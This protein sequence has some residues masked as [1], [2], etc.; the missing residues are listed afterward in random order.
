MFLNVP[1]ALIE[2]DFQDLSIGVGVR[3][4]VYI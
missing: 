3:F 1:K 4:G 2:F